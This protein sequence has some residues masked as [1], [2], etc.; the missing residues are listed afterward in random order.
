MR[1]LVLVAVRYLHWFDGYML[2]AA[3]YCVI[4]MNLLFN[5]CFIM[6]WIV[7]FFFKVYK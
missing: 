4:W 3:V 1:L 6:G 2:Y 7:F 5:G